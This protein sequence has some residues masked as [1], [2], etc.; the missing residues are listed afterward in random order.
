MDFKWGLVTFFFLP[1]NAGDIFH[2]ISPCNLSY[3]ENSFFGY[4]QPSFTI[5]IHT[6]IYICIYISKLA[7]CDT[8]VS[9]SITT[10]PRWCGGRYSVPCI[11]PLTLLPYLIMLMLSKDVLGTIFWVLSKTWHGIE[12]YSQ[13]IIWRKSNIHDLFVVYNSIKHF[14]LQTFLLLYIYIY[15]YIYICVCVCVCVCVCKRQNTYKIRY[16]RLEIQ[17]K[18]GNLGLPGKR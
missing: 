14:L 4:S 11:A 13:S 6:Y 15:I 8:K 5:Y 2:V 10:T 7:D 12:P 17:W 16:I 1:L 9:F 3:I 18:I